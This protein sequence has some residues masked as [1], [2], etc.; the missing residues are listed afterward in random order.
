MKSSLIKI[1]IG[2][3][4]L[5]NKT[6]I[7]TLNDIVLTPNGIYDTNIVAVLYATDENGN[8]I[9]ATSDKFSHVSD[10]TYEEFYPSCHKVH[11]KS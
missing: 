2:E 9:S 10:V 5:Y 7:V 1:K 11:I 8:T 6:R 4:L 3:C